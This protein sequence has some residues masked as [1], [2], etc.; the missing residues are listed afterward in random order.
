MFR[1]QYGLEESVLDKVASHPFLAVWVNCLLP[2]PSLDL[3]P[4]ALEIKVEWNIFPGD[5][6]HF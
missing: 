6:P 2:D 3:P 4:P 5:G 1:E